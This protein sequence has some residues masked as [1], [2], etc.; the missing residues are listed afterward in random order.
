PAK[1]PAGALRLRVGRTPTGRP[2]PGGYLGFS[3]EFTTVEAYSGSDP[4]HLNPTFLQLVRNLNPGQSPW[5]RIGGD[6][7]DWSWWPVSGVSKPRG[8]SFTITPSWL[9]VVRA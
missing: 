6:S 7:T 2:L 8:V 1:V 3:L 9:R 5:I 4:S